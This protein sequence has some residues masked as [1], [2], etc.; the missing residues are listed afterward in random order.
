[1]TATWKLR[2]PAQR[3]TSCS[4]RASFH[5]QSWQSCGALKSPG[6]LGKSREVISVRGEDPRDRKYLADVVK[7]VSKALRKMREDQVVKATPD[8]TG[9]LVYE[10]RRPRNFG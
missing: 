8:N 7:R 3:G 1:M 2:C 10:L 6:A 5:G 9:T 4:G